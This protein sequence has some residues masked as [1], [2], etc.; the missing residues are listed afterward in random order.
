MKGGD[1]DRGCTD[2]AAASFGSREEMHDAAVRTPRPLVIP[3]R[4]VRSVHSARKTVWK[5][6]FGSTGNRT[7]ALSSSV[8][9]VRFAP[10]WCPLDEKNAAP[11]GN[12]GNLGNFGYLCSAQRGKAHGNR[13]LEKT[14]VADGPATFDYLSVTFGYL[15]YRGARM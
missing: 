4:L 7:G 3:V 13:H 5:Q 15:R 12:A 1:R 9:S 10:S 2:V 14:K 8:R 6:R 11:S